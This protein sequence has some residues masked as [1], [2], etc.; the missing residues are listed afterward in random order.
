MVITQPGRDAPKKGYE[1]NHTSEKP[2]A[3]LGV[4]FSAE[5]STP[6]IETI[7]LGSPA[8]KIGILEGDQIIQF[9]GVSIST[10]EALAE[11][12]TKRSPGEKVEI[13]IQRGSEE[14]KVKPIFGCPPSYCCWLFRS[15]SL[16][17]R[18]PT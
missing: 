4:T 17:T 10:V 16:P 14:V 7:E 12:L 2:S 6:V 13:L 3:Y 9:E 8:D 11:L 5:S 15:P 18:R 1:L